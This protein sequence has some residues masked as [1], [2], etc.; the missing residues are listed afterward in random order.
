MGLEREL[1][2][3]ERAARQAA[4]AALRRRAGGITADTKADGSPVTQA[5]RESERIITSILRD[6]FPQD[7]ILGEEWGETPS[8]SGRRWIVDPIDGTRDYVRGNGCWSVLIGLEADGESVAGICYLPEWNRMYTASRG[9]GAWCNGRPV[10][11]SRITQA[12][13]AVVCVSGLDLMQRMPFGG[14]MLEW[15][16]QFW[17]VRSMGGCVD[18]MLVASGSAEVWIEP[19]CASWDL[20]PMKVILEEAGARFFNFDGGSSI[21]AGN[22]VGCVPALEDELRRLVG[23]RM[24]G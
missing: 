5:D 15:L 23:C 2:M 7:G 1:V 11:T 16:K 4:E 22:C 14:R 9:D 6:A 3:M 24:Q 12:S 18:A 20:A 10:R 17:A 19:E 13:Q 8:R 21:H